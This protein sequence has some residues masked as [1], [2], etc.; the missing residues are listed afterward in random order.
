MKR[1]LFLLAVALATLPLSAQEESDERILAFDSH[2]TVNR[3]ASMLVV[4]TIRV[5]SAGESIKHGIYRDFPTSYPGR[6]GSRYTVIFEAV[7]LERDGKPEHL[8]HR[9]PQ[10]RRAHLLW[11]FQLHAAGG[12]SYL[13]L[14]LPHHPATRLLQRP[15]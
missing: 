11:D 6:F 12:D 2:I 13:P 7:S 8:P 1:F 4:E 3:D 15:R 14:H 10:Q 5:R 9:G